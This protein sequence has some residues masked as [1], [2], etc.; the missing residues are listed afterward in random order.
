MRF[1]VIFVSRDLPAREPI[2]SILSNEMLGIFTFEKS[3]LTVG[4]IKQ[5]DAAD[6]PSPSKFSSLRQLK[7]FL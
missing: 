1:F 3:S 6:N 7:Y 5:I 2:K 4:E